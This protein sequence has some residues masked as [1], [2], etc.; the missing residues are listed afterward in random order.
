[1]GKITKTVTQKIGNGN[2]KTLIEKNIIEKICIITPSSSKKDIL[3][4]IN[5]YETHNISY[6]SQPSRITNQAGCVFIITGK[7]I[8]EEQAITVGQSQKMIK[9][10]E[11]IIFGMVTGSGKYAEYSE[12]LSEYSELLIYNVWIDKYLYE[13][14]KIKCIG[15]NIQKAMYEMCKE[16]LVEA[17]LAYKLA[18]KH[19][20]FFGSGMDKRMYYHLIDLIDEGIIQ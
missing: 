14:F 16:Y 11:N 20:G 8:T 12:L 13:E 2:L 3:E 9:E 5:T 15:D 17:S 4:C 1:M 7:R 10:I 19:W 18:A 6:F